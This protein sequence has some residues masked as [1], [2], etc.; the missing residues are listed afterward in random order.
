MRKLMRVMAIFCAGIVMVAAQDIPPETVQL[1]HIRSHMAALLTR[2]PNYTCVETVERSERSSGRKTFQLVDTLRLEVA[3]VDGKEMFAWP[4]AKKFESDDVRDMVKNGAVGNGNFA[5]F[6]A[7]IFDGAGPVFMYRGIEDGVARYDYHVSLANSGYT[8]RRNTREAT[9]A[10]HGW[11]LADPKTLDVEEIEVIA[12]Q[13]PGELD[14]N[15]T[16]TRMDYARVKIGESDFL[17]PAKSEMLMTDADGRE[18]RNFVRLASC[19]QFTGES[20]LTFGDEP[21]ESATKAAPAQEVTLPAGMRL[22]LQ[23]TDEIDMAK[24]AIGDPVHAKLNGDA[25]FKGTVLI[26]KGATVSGRIVRLAPAAP[27]MALGLEFD[28]AQNATVRAHFKGNIDSI[29]EGAFLPGGTSR[30]PF[31]PIRRTP[32]GEF[33]IL[34]RSGKIR[35]PRGTGLYWRTIE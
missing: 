13:I 19:R 18:F 24:A 15:A 7:A 16:E 35:I 30:A 27:Y 22:S 4:G 26:A 9:V 6:A 33:V 1:A 5:N 8:I 17:L 12:E 25:K 28:E 14:L 31:D 29:Q 34:I 11:I 23:L 20:V 2:Q 32:S 21:A 3:L 10:Y